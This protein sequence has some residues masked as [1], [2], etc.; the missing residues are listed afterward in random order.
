MTDDKAS[1]LRDDF[2][3]HA[4]RMLT[5]VFPFMKVQL[6]VYV[7]VLEACSQGSSRNLS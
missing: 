2:I 7:Y 3:V 1:E 4:G 6:C 5:S